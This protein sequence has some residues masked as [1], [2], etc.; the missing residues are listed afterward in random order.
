MDTLR[1]SEHQAYRYRDHHGGLGVGVLR[2]VRRNDKTT[3][4]MNATTCCRSCALAGLVLSATLVYC[5]P[6]FSGQQPDSPFTL[7]D[8]LVYARQHSPRL[9]AKRQGITSEQAAIAAARAE[10]L[11]RL[12]LGATARG[13]SQPTE[14]AM[15]FPLTQLA[16]IPEG[17]PFRRGHLNADVR[18]T[19]PLY[20]G[21]RIRSA[22]SLAEAQRDL[23]QVTV[24]DV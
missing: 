21:G 19:M 4:D 22:V 13:S 10:R 23:A 14:T 3:K 20:T 11:P 18:A 5:V 1:L 12:A 17:Q 7:D 15:G 6:C 9:S 24:H 8:A 16:D 2:P